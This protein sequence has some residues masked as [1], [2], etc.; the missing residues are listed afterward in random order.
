MQFE[1]H[2][3]SLASKLDLHLMT[4]AHLAKISKHHLKL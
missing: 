1:M 4:L 3:L 2:P